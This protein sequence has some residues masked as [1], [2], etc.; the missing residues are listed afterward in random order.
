MAAS[1]TSGD[2]M[3]SAAA[4]LNDVSKSLFTYT[5]QMPYLKIANDELE[6]ELLQ[7]NAT[8]EDMM[9]N[10]NVAANALTLT[11]P[12]DFFMPIKLR[13]RD[14]TSTN[15]DDFFDMYEKDLEPLLSKTASLNYWSFRNNA[16]NFIG[17]TTNRTVKLAYKRTLVVISN[18]NGTEVEEVTKAKNFLAFRTA[19]LCAEFIGGRNGKDRALSLNGQAIVAITSLTNI[20]VKNSQGRRARRKPFRVRMGPYI[21]R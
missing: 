3:D 17:A 8:I 7:Y 10:I 21:I 15:D 4:L 13:E 14:Q 1:Y 18:V 2:V 11:L 16:I 5:V 19:A 6:A 12:A 9:T 20:F